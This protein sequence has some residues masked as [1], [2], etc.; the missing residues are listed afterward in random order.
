MVKPPKTL[1]NPITGILFQ[2][3]LVKKN[4]N[5]VIIVPAVMFP[6]NRIESEIIGAKL[7]TISK[8][9]GARGICFPLLVVIFKKKFLR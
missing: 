3:Q 1:I 6:H 7:L 4:H 5:V 8:G 9:L 2:I